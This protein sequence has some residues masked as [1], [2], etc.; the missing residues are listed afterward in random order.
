MA[1][2]DELL[3]R[4]ESLEHTGECEDCTRALSRRALFGGLLAGGIAMMT[5]GG[6]SMQA[7]F[8]D[9]NYTGDTL[10]VLSLRGGMDGL[11]AIA[12]IG[13]KDYAPVRPTTAISA[14]SG[15]QLDSMFAL[16]PALA[17]IKGLWDQGQFAAVHA[18]GTMD[19]T[20]SHFA[21]MEQIENAAPGTSVRTG[22]LDRVMGQRTATTPFQ[23]TTVGSSTTPRMALGPFPEMVIPSL[24][25]TKLNAA[26]NADALAQWATLTN[27][28]HAR[29]DSAFATPVHSALAASMSA[30]N[31]KT[32]TPNV[33][34]PKTAL[35]G[36]LSDVAAMIKSG[37]GLQ[38]AT[39]DQ[40]DWDHHENAATRM[41]TNL[42][43]L[44]DALAAFA[45]DLGPAWQKV[46]VVTLSEFG[47]RVKENGSA[48]FD[49]GHGNAMMIA[50]GSGLTSS[51]VFGTWPG[52]AK[53]NLRG[54][55]DLA[56]TT[57]YRS[58]FAELLTQRAG[59]SSSQVATA[60][61]N[62]SPSS[63]GVFKQA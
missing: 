5:S 29:T 31:M 45:A 34:Y 42:G 33:T 38:I 14:S 58:V 55:E 9:A 6:L 19:Q 3:N 16:N 25:A 2:F 11:S 57:D 12:P 35:G 50:S 56:G 40:G 21:A 62:F 51:K 26:S 15:I 46:T 37:S 49:H 20:R 24:S 36:A 41:T 8:A 4:D 39:V 59:M 27:A 52:L 30:M 18:V 23:A 28:M 60:F 1:D 7:A 43:Y 22:W 48:G 47:R 17:P 10:V 53:A 63:V 54:G 61:P 32:V 44:A 13:D